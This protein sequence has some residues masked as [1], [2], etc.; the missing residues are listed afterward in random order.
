MDSPVPISTTTLA[1]A[2]VASELVFDEAHDRLQLQWQSQQ[3]TGKRRPLYVD[4]TGPRILR[5]SRDSLRKQALCRA[6]GIKAGRP[7]PKVLDATAGLGSDAF[8]LACAGCHVTMLERSPLVHA[9]LED[10]IRRAR[11]DSAVADIVA[12]MTLH[13]RDFIG[14]EG[15]E[16]D[17]GDEWR[18]DT[19][20]LDPMYSMGIFRRAAAG[21]NMAWLQEILSEE[22]EGKENHQETEE[23]ALLRQ[24]KSIA[25]K[26]IAVKRPRHCPP[27]AGQKPD[28]HY[29]GSSS[30]YDVYILS[31][32]PS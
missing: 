4:F 21:R 30:R 16:R 15:D 20:Y 17:E 26:R 10:G 31:S 9:L 13:H 28:I 22:A 11:A 1:A 23:P 8:L 24:A 29:P 32:T 14:D 3:K 5:R 6:V 27:L 2:S 7:L 18:A 19:V 12:R 25:S